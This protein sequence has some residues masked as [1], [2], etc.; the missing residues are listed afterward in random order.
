MNSIN[1][2]LFLVNTCLILCMFIW[3]SV[4]CVNAYFAVFSDSFKTENALGQIGKKY[5]VPIRNPESM[6]NM[7]TGTALTF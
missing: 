5:T 7:L 4:F 6:V 3:S 2:H 1:A